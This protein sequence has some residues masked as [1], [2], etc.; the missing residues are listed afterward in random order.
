MRIK[1]EPLEV[2]SYKVVLKVAINSV[3]KAYS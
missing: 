3:S 2:Q 1:R